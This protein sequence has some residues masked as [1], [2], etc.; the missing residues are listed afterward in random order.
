MRERPW[1]LVLGV[2]FLVALHPGAAQ[3][4]DLHVDPKERVNAVYH[5]AC[6]PTVLDL[7]LNRS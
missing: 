2:V 1:L 3:Q 4:V 5:L 7:K 6:S